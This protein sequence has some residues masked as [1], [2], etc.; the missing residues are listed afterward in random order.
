V[1]DLKKSAAELVKADK[2]TISHRGQACA[3]MLQSLNAQ[4]FTASP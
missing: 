2:N 1:A 3:L 4:P